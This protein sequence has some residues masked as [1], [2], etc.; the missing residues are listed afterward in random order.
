MLY[1]YQT[2]VS[3]AGSDF[4]L[5]GGVTLPMS[6]LFRPSDMF[7]SFTVSAIDDNILETDESF[8]LSLFKSIDVTNVN[9]APSLTT[10]TIIDN[11]G[12]D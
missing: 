3:L 11:E 6:F 5:N 4:N 12:G 8:S 7:L 1:V 10:I 9:I 2:L